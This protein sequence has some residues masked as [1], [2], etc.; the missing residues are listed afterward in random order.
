M[1]CDLCDNEIQPFEE[2]LQVGDT[3]ICRDCVDDGMQEYDPDGDYIDIQVN[4]DIER[5]FGIA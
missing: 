5:R 2:F 4:E 3:V 1:I